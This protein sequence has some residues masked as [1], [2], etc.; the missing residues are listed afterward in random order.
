MKHKLLF[1][2]ITLLSYEALIAQQNPTG[3]PQSGNATNPS[4]AIPLANAA[5]YR[6]GNFPVGGS[7]SKA[8]IFGTMW[9]N[10]IYTVTNG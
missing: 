8:N 4:Q 2:L 10:P 3:T 5:W 9:N 7:P 6:G 1:A